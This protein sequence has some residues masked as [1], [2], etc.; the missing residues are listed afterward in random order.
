MSASRPGS[1]SRAASSSSPRPGGCWRASCAKPSYKPG[2]IHIGG[3]TDPYQPQERRLRVTRGVLETL[4]RFGHPFS[5]I[6][7]SALI[8]RDADIIG[9]M[10]ARTWRARPSR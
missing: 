6:T 8:L 7:K 5:I 9:P 4:E 2:P 1:T 10:G 3:N